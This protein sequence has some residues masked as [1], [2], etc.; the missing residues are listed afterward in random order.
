M[1]PGNSGAAF[2]AYIECMFYS[3][4]DNPVQQAS[5]MSDTECP[6]LNQDAWTH[7]PR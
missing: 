4:W 3:R 7:N 6:P 2:V 1:L 5:N